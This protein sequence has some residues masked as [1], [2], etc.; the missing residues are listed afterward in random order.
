M[1]DPGSVT[2]SA[3]IESAASVE[4]APILSDF[5]QRVDREACRRGFD[6]AVRRVVLGDG[7]VWIWNLADELFPGAVQIVDLYH[8]KEHLAGVAKAIYGAASDLARQWAKQRH[9]DLDA[10]DLDAV[11]EAVHAHAASNT[12]AE[13]CVGYLTRNLHRI[14]YPEFRAR[15]LCVS[16]GVV[17][18]GCKTAIGAR[19]KRSGMHWSVGGA[20]AIIALRCCRLSGR[21]EDY[22][23]RRAFSGQGVRQRAS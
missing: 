3:A 4:A 21:F 16:T 18:S 15:G 6:H 22:W 5:A 12:E 1:R 17:E 8:A 19:L 11:L 2:Y 20:D 9:D 14:R 7:A 10:G 23:E 13:K